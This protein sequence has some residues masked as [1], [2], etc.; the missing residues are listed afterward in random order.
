MAQQVF[1]EHP[2]LFLSS[3]LRPEPTGALKILSHLAAVSSLTGETRLP[4]LSGK[5]TI[6]LCVSKWKMAGTK[7]VPLV[8]ETK[9]TYPSYLQGRGTL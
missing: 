1:F 2:G 9:K 6:H 5:K 7:H 3:G 4:F 8:S